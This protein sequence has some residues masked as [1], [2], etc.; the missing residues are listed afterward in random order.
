MEKMIMN[1]ECGRL[2]KDLK[3]FMVISQHFPGG[4]AKNLEN[5]NQ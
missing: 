4:S 3:Y 1:D 2:L 5:H